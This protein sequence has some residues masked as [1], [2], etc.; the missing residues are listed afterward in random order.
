LQASDEAAALRQTGAARIPRLSAAVEAVAALVLGE[1]ATAGVKLAKLRA[2]VGGDP[3]AVPKRP[4]VR[5]TRVLC[6]SATRCRPGAVAA[7]GNGATPRR[8]GE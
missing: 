6:H 4:P 8:G 5:V 7:E 2:T 1:F 3:A